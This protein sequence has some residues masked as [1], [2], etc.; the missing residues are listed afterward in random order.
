MTLNAYEM[1]PNGINIA[2]FYKKSPETE[3]SP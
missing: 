3:A 2:F 1:R